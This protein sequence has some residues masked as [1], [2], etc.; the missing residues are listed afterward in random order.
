MTYVYVLKSS[1]FLFIIKYAFLLPLFI[2]LDLPIKRVGCVNKLHQSDIK[3]ILICSSQVLCV[4][5]S[6]YAYINIYRYKYK[7]YTYL[8]ELEM[9]DNLDIPCLL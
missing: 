2:F 9:F 6:T 7:I 8:E 1:V 5:M 3:I 4:Y